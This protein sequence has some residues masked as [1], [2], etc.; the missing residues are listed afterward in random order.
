MECYVYLCPKHILFRYIHSAENHTSHELRPISLVFISHNLNRLPR[1][2]CT[3]FKQIAHYL[4]GWPHHTTQEAVLLISECCALQNMC[5]HRCGAG[6][7][8]M[9]KTFSTPQARGSP[10]MHADVASVKVPDATSVL[11]NR[12]LP[13]MCGRAVCLSRVPKIWQRLLVHLRTWKMVVQVR[14]SG[15]KTSQS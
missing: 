14:S 2:Y 4:L 3:K 1:K 13:L 9:A 11:L 5:M 12:N 8:S 15:T 7:W 10:C 6:L